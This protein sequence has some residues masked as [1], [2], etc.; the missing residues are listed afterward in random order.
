MRARVK[1][2]AVI[3]MLVALAVAITVSRREFRPGDRQEAGE[4]QEGRR[5]GRC[6]RTSSA[7]CRYTAPTRQRRAAHVAGRGEDRAARSPIG[8]SWSRSPAQYNWTLC[9]RGDPEPSG[10]RAH[11]GGPVRRA[12]RAWIS[13]AIRTALR[14]T[15]TRRSLHGSSSSANFVR[16]YGAHGSFWAAHPNLPYHPTTSYRDLERAKPQVVLGRHPEPRRLS[17]A[18]QDQQARR[19]AARTQAPQIVFGGLFPFPMPQYGVKALKFL[20]S[21]FRQQGRQEVVQRALAAPVLVYAQAAGARR[22]GCSAR[23][24]TPIAPGRSRSG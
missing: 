7:W 22:S 13:P 16:R 4:A 12:R 10:R 18:P 11:P 3:G 6:L 24:S 23:T 5:T 17:E 1:T 21:F 14:S 20:N 9:R 15:A 8:S 2:T 19:L